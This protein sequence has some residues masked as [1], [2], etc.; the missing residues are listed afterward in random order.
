MKI[1][2]VKDINLLNTESFDRLIVSHPN[3]NFFQSLKAFRLFSS[4][5]N[6]KPVLIIAEEAGEVVGSLLASIIRENNIVKG[7]LSR[8]CIIYG[9]PIIK[10]NNFQTA[11][12]LLQYFD[13]IINNRVIYTE[14]RELYEMNEFDISF[15]TYGYEYEDHLNFIVPIC[16]IIENKKLCSP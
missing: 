7:Y 5:E 4:V 9:G 8:R 16:S 15:K 11:N 14:F 1:S 2:L 13:R 3:G 12:S 6:F 10:D